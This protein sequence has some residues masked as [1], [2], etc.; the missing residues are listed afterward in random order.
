MNIGKLNI[1]SFKF[2]IDFFL[3]YLTQRA[4][5]VL[6]FFLPIYWKKKITIHD[7]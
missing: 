1:F 4:D 3:F 6:K 5:K 7:I 2:K